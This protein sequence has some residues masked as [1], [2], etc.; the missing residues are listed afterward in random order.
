MQRTTG[1]PASEAKSAEDGFG[2]CAAKTRVPPLTP[3][4]QQLATDNYRL[5]LWMANKAYWRHHRRFPL[6]DLL[7]T[8]HTALVYA[9]ARYD[10]TRGK[11]GP[12]PFG[13]FAGVVIRQQLEMFA[14]RGNAR[15]RRSLDFA[16]CISELHDSEE[17]LEFP[18]QRTP[19]PEVQ[20]LIAEILRLLREMLPEKVWRLLE[21][22]FLEGES[23]SDIARS[24]G[25]SHQRV[26]QRMVKALAAAPAGTL[27][28]TAICPSS[29]RRNSGSARS[30]PKMDA[31]VSIL[32]GLPS[33][34]AARSTRGH[35][36]KKE[37]RSAEQSRPESSWLLANPE[38][39]LPRLKFAPESGNRPGAWLNRK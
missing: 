33:P 15:K 5:A 1:S 17:T 19:P 32:D 4:Q 27:T 7:G 36:L 14:R 24:L 28:A 16:P 9:A 23:Q 11:N 2:P 18:D 3:H 6:D 12:L 39:P 10:S 30:R 13:T 29:R 38:P 8:A 26:Q 22:H 35:S 31:S 25:V 34:R 20:A 37:S 21:R